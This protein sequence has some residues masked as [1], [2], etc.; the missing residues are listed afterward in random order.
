MQGQAGQC[1][2]CFASEIFMKS[3]PSKN[4]LDSPRRL[5]DVAVCIWLFTLAKTVVQTG[6]GGLSVMALLASLQRRT[7]K[8]E[9]NEP[10]R[11]LTSRSGKSLTHRVIWEV[12]W[13]T[14]LVRQPEAPQATLV[15]TVV[16]NANVHTVPM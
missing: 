2:R 13:Q 9:L 6:T 15:K 10:S 12:G 3:V 5:L 7:Q 14:H 1:L 16:I 4:V 8:C 11:Q